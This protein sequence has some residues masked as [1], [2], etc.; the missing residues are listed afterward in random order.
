[1]AKR[2]LSAQDRAWMAEDAMRTLTRAAE[3]QADKRLMADV[4]KVAK[5]QI[6]TLSKVAAPAKP[7]SRKKK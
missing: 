7:A 5:A 1:M 2:P 6:Q 4:K 3:I